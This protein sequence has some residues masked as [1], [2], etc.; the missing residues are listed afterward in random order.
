[1]QRPLL[2]K[3]LLLSVLGLALMLPLGM[4]E[5]TISERSYYRSEAVRSIAASTAGPQTLI[6]PILVI[7][8]REEYDDEVPVAKDDE[9]RVRIVRRSRTQVLTVLPKRLDV[10]GS[11]GVERRAYGIH[12]ASVFELQGSLKGSFDPPSEADLPT[13]GRNSV[14]TWGKPSL[15]L[16]ISDVR[17][18]SGEPKVK[19]G[20][21]DLVVARGAAPSGLKSGFHAELAAAGLPTKPLSFRVDLKLAGTESIAIAPLAELTTAELRGNWPHPSFG[22]GFLP[23]ER[24]VGE[25]GFRAR[26]SV[27]ALA[28]DIQRDALGGREG[29]SLGDNA[30]FR[31]R[32]I[33]PVDIYQQA[34]RAVKYGV[35]FIVLIFA[36]FFAFETIKALPIHPIQY[37]LVGLAI[38]VFFLLLVSLSEHIAFAWSYLAAAAAS[39]ALITIYLAAV[40]RGWR[41]GLSAGSALGLLYGAL[42]GVLRSEQNALLLG[43]VLLFVV[44]AALMLGTRKVDWY[45]VGL[46]NL[47]NNGGIRS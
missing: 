25:D 43:S 28:A 7:P 31:I 37:L 41:P 23:R 2:W 11:L 47:R 21:S 8:V 10:D 16:G 32:L 3:C 36:G 20:E 12:E 29:H 35:L 14:L 46:G 4:I 18:L 44:L 33:D 19:V 17:G 6:G 9:G 24:Q 27:S 5:R 15:V 30:V 34:T 42:F 45:A 38:A 40:L 1:M 13:R 26:W 22:G 39:I